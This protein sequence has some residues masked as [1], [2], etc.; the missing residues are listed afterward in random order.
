MRGSFA[1][2]AA[3][4]VPP[5]ITGVNVVTATSI[6]ADTSTAE[7]SASTNGNEYITLRA[8][9]DTVF[10]VFGATGMAAAT[11]SNAY[12][13]PAG[14]SEEFF[15]P[16]GTTHFRAISTLASTLQWFISG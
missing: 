12:P 11:T 1:G 15:L 8:L 9:S 16:K 5:G 14:D 10:V 3:R 7:V 13:I 4:R 2:Q 6:T